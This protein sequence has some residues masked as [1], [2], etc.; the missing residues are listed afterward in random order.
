MKDV[1]MW[2]IIAFLVA[3]IFATISTIGKVRPPI[4]NGLALTVTLL[5]SLVI[6]GVLYVGDKI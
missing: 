4:T 3:G 2:L 1:V 5:N 6:I